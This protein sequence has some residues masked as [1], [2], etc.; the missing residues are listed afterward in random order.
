MKSG[1]RKP[2]IKNPLKPLM[3]YSYFPLGGSMAS[4]TNIQLVKTLKHSRSYLRDFFVNGF[5]RRNDYPEKSRRSYD[6]EKRRIESWLSHCMKYRKEGK[7]KIVFLSIDSREFGSNPLFRAFFSKSFSDKDVIF[8]FCLINALSEKE[9]NLNEL[10]DALPSGLLENLDTS[11]I[12]KKCNEYS[13][14]GFLTKRQEGQIVY[15]GLAPSVEIEELTDAIAF[16]SETMPLGAV[17][18]YLIE[19]SQQE[20]K[21]P[22]ESK[23]AKETKETKDPIPVSFKHHYIFSALDQEILERL[24]Q[25]IREK[26]NVRLLISKEGDAQKEDISLFPWKIFISTE[27]GRQYILGLSEGQPI[28][29]RLD[30]IDTVELL[31]KDAKASEKEKILNSFSPHFWGVSSW[32]FE[33]LHHVEMVVR[34]EKEESFISKRLEKEKRNGIVTRVTDKDEISRLQHLE[35]E[36]Q[37]AADAPEFWK[38]KVDLYDPQEMRPWLRTFIGHIVELHSDDPS[39]EEK[40]WEDMESMYKNYEE[41]AQ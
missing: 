33:T 41:D 15:Y 1:I 27:S 7:E 29:R 6:D 34:V 4:N 10:Q 37:N 17:G 13:D 5:K 9:M 21:D 28:F 11:N 14:L 25:G 32:K 36:S 22:K 39:L 40:F 18:Q 8:Y 12:R 26:K 20:T 31:K 3:F 30:R 23:E 19:N 38:Y 24:L 16:A 2:P 35:E